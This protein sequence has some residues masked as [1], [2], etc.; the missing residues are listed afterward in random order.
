MM[1]SLSPERF[2]FALGVVSP[3]G[4]LPKYFY[5]LASE[6]MTISCT[7]ERRSRST[8]GVVC[9]CTSSPRY[10]YLSFVLFPGSP[11]GLS[12][13]NT[14]ITTFFS[15]TLVYDMSGYVLVLSAYSSPWILFTNWMW[16][17]C[18]AFV[19]R[20][21]S[22]LRK[23][24]KEAGFAPDTF[25]PNLCTS[26]RNTHACEKDDRARS[27]AGFTWPVMKYAAASR[28]DWSSMGSASK[29]ADLSSCETPSIHFD[30][31]PSNTRDKW[32]WK[33]ELLSRTMQL[34]LCAHVSALLKQHESARASCPERYPSGDHWQI[35]HRTQPLWR[36]LNSRQ[37]S[38]RRWALCRASLSPLFYS[39]SRLFSS[40]PREQI[41]SH[42]SVGCIEPESAREHGRTSIPR[43]VATA[44]VDDDTNSL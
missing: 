12:C 37:F 10:S 21:N 19:V 28:S 43:N 18:H 41:F 4:S 9:P 26:F 16:V 40:Y 24:S 7:P 42:L 6:T 11:S 2:C 30:S 32:G 35:L 36:T 20:F 15:L 1:I 8:T 34:G 44:L 25:P 3:W 5:R 13:L 22:R 27:G 23:A 14:H 33:S 29:T 39:Q 17:L 38:G 31:T